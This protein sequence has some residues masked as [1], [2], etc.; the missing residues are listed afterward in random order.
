MYKDDEFSSENKEVLFENEN[1]TG[2]ND[3][4]PNANTPVRFL[5]ATSII[6]DK[7]ENMNGE[8]LGEIKNI[9]MNV[10]TGCSEYVVLEFGSFL[11]IG[12]KLFAIPFKE[13]RLVSGRKVFILDKDK[14]YLKQAPGF[15]K[16][17]WPETN[18]RHYNEVD[19]YWYNYPNSG[20]VGVP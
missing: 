9:M 12:G 7:V 2:I 13:F 19:S 4:S 17:H 5:T 18:S 10:Y 8:T 14:D 16:E 11:G 20:S 15:D 3:E 1:L 6:G